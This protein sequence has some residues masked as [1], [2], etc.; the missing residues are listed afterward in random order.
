MSS[1][2]TVWNGHHAW[3]SGSLDCLPGS[4]SGTAGSLQSDS[5]NQQARQGG[6]AACSSACK[7]A[8]PVQLTEYVGRWRRLEFSFCHCLLDKRGLDVA[9]ITERLR[10]FSIRTVFNLSSAIFSLML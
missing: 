3:V 1:W 4:F 7:A 10:E 6:E 5:S 8:T 9:D 2:G